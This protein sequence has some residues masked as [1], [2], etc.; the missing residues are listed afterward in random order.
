MDPISIEYTSAPFPRRGPDR[1]CFVVA[2]EKAAQ[3]TLGF[4]YTSRLSHRIKLVPSWST[5][6]M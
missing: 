4:S 2:V 6:G 1:V 5:M 3:R